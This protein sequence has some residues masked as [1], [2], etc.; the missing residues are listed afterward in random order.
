VYGHGG[1]HAVYFARKSS[2][3]LLAKMVRAIF[4]LLLL[5]SGIRAADTTAHFFVFLDPMPGRPS[6]DMDSIKE[7]QASH[8]VAMDQ[9]YREKK[10]AVTGPFVDS[11]GGEIFVIN[12]STGDEALAIVQT[13]PL[14]K[15]HRFVIRVSGVETIAGSIC[16]PPELY[17]LAKYPFAVLTETKTCSDEHRSS[18]IAYYQDLVKRKKIVYAARMQKDNTI[19]VVFAKNDLVAPAFQIAK[20][21]PAVRAGAMRYTVRPWMTSSGVFCDFTQ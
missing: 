1:M 18:Q 5:C 2:R 11:T 16:E 14:V 4:F 15:A 8:L 9:L 20:H 12:A 10:L 6:L 17:D 13:N 7:F 21:D 3:R 19:V